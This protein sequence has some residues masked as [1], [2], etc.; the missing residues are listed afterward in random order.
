[1]FDEQIPAHFVQ[2]A[3]EIL[4]D[5]S[6]GLSGANIVRSTATYAVKGKIVLR[7]IK[8]LVHRLQSKKAKS[9]FVWVPSKHGHRET[10][11]NT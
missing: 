6:G 3:V 8:N 5:T 1:M 4:G 10:V 2:Y 9:P 7:K 11:F